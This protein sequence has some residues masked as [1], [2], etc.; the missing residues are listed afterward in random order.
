[1]DPHVLRLAGAL[2]GD[3]TEIFIDS[4]AWDNTAGL[5]VDIIS[6]AC[7]TLRASTL[8][9][10]VTLSAVALATV[11]VVDLVGTAL[12]PAYSL[13]D[14]IDLANGA[15]C[16]VIVDEVVAGLADASTRDPI[17]VD[18]ADGSADAVATLA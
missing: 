6:L 5:L 11:E 16:A 17:L 15:L 13:V 14:I 9:D 3:L 10:V 1:M 4:P 18:V 8:D 12:D 7:Q 2:L